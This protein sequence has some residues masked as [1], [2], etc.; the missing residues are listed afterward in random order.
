MTSIP[1]LHLKWRLFRDLIGHPQ[2]DAQIAE[3]IFGAEGAAIKFTKLRFGD[4]GLSPEIA[5]ELI[6]TINRR[7]EVYRKA[8]QLP[9]QG[10]NILSALDLE[11]PVYDFAHRLLGAVDHKISPDALERA[12]RELLAEMAPKPSQTASRLKIER[13]SG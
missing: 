2:A 9:A 6:S 1:N 8:Q 4:L 5:T 12:H 3:S 10:C 11:L 7:L 13:Y